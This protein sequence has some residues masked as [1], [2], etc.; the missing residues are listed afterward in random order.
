MPF[1]K[2]ARANLLASK[3]LFIGECEC[4]RSS[5]TLFIYYFGWYQKKSSSTEFYF[6][7]FFLFS[8]RFGYSF[9]TFFGKCFAIH[10]VSLNVDSIGEPTTASTPDDTPISPSIT[11]FHFCSNNF[12]WISPRNCEPTQSHFRYPAQHRFPKRSDRGFYVCVAYVY[13][14]ENAKKLAQYFASVLLVPF[15]FS[16]L[17]SSF[18]LLL[19]RLRSVVLLSATILF[20]IQPYCMDV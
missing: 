7:S 11:W 18:S 13:Q 10:A 14:A 12:D 9:F 2:N 20:S 8:P 5:I 6:S 3:P 19:H 17:S 4:F 1:N 15:Y 16:S